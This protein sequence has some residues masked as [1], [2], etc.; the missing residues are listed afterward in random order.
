[1]EPWSETAW[2]AQMDQLEAGTLVPPTCPDCR[3]QGFFGPRVAEGPRK[4]WLCKFCGHYREPARNP[5]RCRPTAHTC[6]DWPRVLGSPYI[7][8][9]RP[10]DA[11]FACPFCGVE[12]QVSTATTTSPATD[13]R[14][15]WWQVPQG[16][17]FDQAAAFWA[18]NDQG[19][20]YL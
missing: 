15:P 14:H 1:M 20:V 8:W 16:L 5:L 6:V 9:T 10:E 7:W 4:Y 11:A 13:P 19:R 2:Q 3:R 12:V 18:R 17:N